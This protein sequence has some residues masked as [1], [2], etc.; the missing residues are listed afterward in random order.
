MDVEEDRIQ[1]LVREIVR[2]KIREVNRNS[3]NVRPAVSVVPVS[4]FHNVNDEL[5]PRFNFPSQS[6][7]ATA[8]PGNSHA[9]R[10]IAS[11]FNPAANYGTRISQRHGRRQRILPYARQSSTST[12]TQL[13]NKNVF[14]L[15]SPSLRK[16]PRGSQKA[17]LQRLGCYVDAL[18][19]SKEMPEIQVKEKLTQVF[20]K[21]LLDSEKPVR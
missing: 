9:L 8:F 15:P 5:S 16:V 2:S 11:N 14:L 13:F 4:T 17:E 19:F 6:T 10:E 18:F 12:T 1:R 20:E 3:N 21:Q 7:A